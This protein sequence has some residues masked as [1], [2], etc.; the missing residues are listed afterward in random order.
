MARNAVAVILK[1]GIYVHFQ[2]AARENG[3]SG[4]FTVDSGPSSGSGHRGG[5]A[6]TRTAG[7]FT[8]EDTGVRHTPESACPACGRDGGADSVVRGATSPA[9]SFAWNASNPVI[10]ASQTCPSQT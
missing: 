10:G 5:G 3:D 7:G 8:G 9:A 4:R 2:G 6:M 1:R